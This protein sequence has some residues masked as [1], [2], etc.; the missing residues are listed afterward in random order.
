MWL[1]YVNPTLF[2]RYVK[3]KA[4]ERNIPSERSQAKVPTQTSLNQRAQSKDPRRS[5]QSDRFLSGVV[6][7]LP[8]RYPGV[9]FPWG[10]SIGAHIYLTLSLLHTSVFQSS[11]FYTSVYGVVGCWAG[12]AREAADALECVRWQS[13]QACNMRSTSSTQHWCT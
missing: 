9:D 8:Q 2:R 11:R 10:P 4:T 5:F 6:Q 12:L 13:N 3:G 7:T 1:I